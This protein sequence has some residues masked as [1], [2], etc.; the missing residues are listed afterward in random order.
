MIQSTPDSPRPYDT[1]RAPD[2]RAVSPDPCEYCQAAT[3]PH[4]AVLTP[5]GWEPCPKG[6]G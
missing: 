3:G 2:G 5:Q 4:G 6:K 1:L